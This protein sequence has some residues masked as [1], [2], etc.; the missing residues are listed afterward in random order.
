[1]SNT[2]QFLTYSGFYIKTSKDAHILIDPF[3]DDNP[4]T[5]FQSTD[6]NGISLILVTHS[7]FDH[8]GDTAK[9]AKRCG[10]WVICPDDVKALLLEQGVPEDQIVSVP[11]GM[12]VKIGQL[13]VKPVENHHRSVLRLPLG[14]FVSSQPLAFM[15]WLE[16][17]TCVYIAG[18]TSIFSDMKL[19]AAL[20]RPHIGIINAVTEVAE[21]EP[22]PGRPHITT[23]E[24]SPYEAA[25]C[26]K[27]MGLQAALPCHYIDPDQNPQVQEYVVSAK[28][29]CPQ[30]KVTVLRD[31]EVFCFSKADEQEDT[32]E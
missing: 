8:V 13:R 20:Y 29:L 7:A 18:D 26:T 11:W 27:W 31:A 17:D 1:M 2:F 25:L 9:I 4:G 5:Q 15:L 6:F 16:D 14:S 32:I 12:T 3:L 22:E 28:T 23:G 10:A 19:Q 24:M 21:Q 30:T